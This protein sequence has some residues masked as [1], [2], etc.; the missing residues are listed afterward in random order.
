MTV[1]LVIS[2]VLLG[3]LSIAL[4]F[5]FWN[6]I[7][8]TDLISVL[9]AGTLPVLF[10][11]ATGVYKR[12]LPLELPVLVTIVL[13]MVL[14]KPGL[15]GVFLLLIL[16]GSVFRV[17]IL[18]KVRESVSA[19]AKALPDKAWIK[20]GGDVASVPAS[21]LIPG[22]LLIVKSG[23]KVPVDGM[24]SSDKA[25]LDESVITGEAN[26]VGKSRGEMLVAASINA[27]DPLEMVAKN[28]TH[29][30]TV[31][32]MH[33][34][35]EEAQQHATPLSR[36]S[37]R[38]AETTSVGAL[39]LVGAFYLVTRDIERSLALWISL[40][41]VIFAII[42]PVSTTIGI[43]LLARSGILVKSAQSLENVTKVDT[44][45]LDKTGTLTLGTPELA[46]TVPARGSG[47]KDALSLAASLERIS[48]HRLA[49][50][51]MDK[52]GKD[53]LDWVPVE[54]VQVR[55]GLGIEGRSRGEAV[56]IGSRAFV[57]SLGAAVPTEILSA[58]AGHEHPGA[59]PVFLARSRS[60]VALFF[61]SDTL[62]AEAPSVMDTLGKDGY[63]I[64]M[65]TGDLPQ[66][67][68]VMSREAHIRE[69]HA[70]L[71]PGEKV[72]VVSKL[73]A[74]GRKVLMVGD[75]LNDALVLAQAD[76]GVAMGLRGV[77][78]T[79]EAAG[80]VLVHDDLTTLETLFRVAKDTFRTIKTN[81]VMATLIHLA[82]AGLVAAG[83]IEIL[84]SAIIHQV[85]STIVLLNTARLFLREERS[86]S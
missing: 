46:A 74:E 86:P 75:G 47:E 24:L 27:G 21:S 44:V 73:K 8:E 12:R 84:G 31:A 76:V 19:L 69:F 34:L 29:Q 70:G 82:A 35:V 17:L 39:F 64:L 6:V 72:A 51:F 37:T 50:P 45:C 63:R 61:I 67:A 57:E 40:V 81:L 23:E 59:T 22:D 33:R 77:D 85:S 16:W 49:E 48:E 43:S 2:L 28:T 25:L 7:S 13:L 15:A 5:Y 10:D 83:S 71:L 32:Q 41:P 60:V 42:V 65:L 36:F 52:L 80:V 4:P 58:L 62:R 3:L 66:V 78:L 54:D 26:P 14:D 38:Y 20:R 30:S 53:G 55:K 56:A 18:R 9:S 68:A 79:L 11:I 1:R